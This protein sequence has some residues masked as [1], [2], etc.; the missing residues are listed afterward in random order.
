MV[1]GVDPAALR[2]A[3]RIARGLIRDGARAVVLTGSHARGDAHA[4]SDI[5][6]VVIGNSRPGDEVPPPR[7]VGPFL[8]TTAVTNAS[9]ARRAF[10]DP[11]LVGANVP[12]WRDA[13][14]LADTGG[15]AVRLQRRARQWSWDA[16]DAACDRWVAANVAGYAEEVHKLVAALDRRDD[17]LAAIQRSILALHLAKV[18]AVHHRILYGSEND[19][20][21]LAGERMG[22][23]WSSAQARALSL[24]GES[25]RVSS[26]AALSM[27]R[28][29]AAE[30]VH[31]LDRRERAVVAHACALAER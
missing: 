7:R 15:V 1:S 11:A 17:A 24:K 22:A 8:V 28:L 14:I 12:G 30:T 21:R 19:M 2:V 16:I 10:L 9:A 3:R 4:E 23:R 5:D 31:L 18:A 27:Y 29:L 25:V 6:L 13:V 26:R 20:W